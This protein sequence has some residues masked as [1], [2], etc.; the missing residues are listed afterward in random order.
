MKMDPLLEPI[1]GGTEKSQAA[2]STTDKRQ[3]LHFDVH[4]DDRD[5]HDK[6]AATLMLSRSP[7]EDNMEQIMLT[8]AENIWL[9]PRIYDN[10]PDVYQIAATNFARALGLVSKKTCAAY[11]LFKYKKRSKSL[12]IQRMPFFIGKGGYSEVDHAGISVELKFNMSQLR[13]LGSKV[14]IMTLRQPIMGRDLITQSHQYAKHAKEMLAR[15]GV[16]VTE[17]PGTPRITFKSQFKTP[18]Q[19]HVFQ[20]WGI[21]DADIGGRRNN[22]ARTESLDSKLGLN[23]DLQALEI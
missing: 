12:Q 3:T 16:Y 10:P 9:F 15:D 20:I 19:R 21:E 22:W 5:E 6:L 13:L 2:P 4:S 1:L 8:S 23:L 17:H 18:T 7:S 11:L 14:K